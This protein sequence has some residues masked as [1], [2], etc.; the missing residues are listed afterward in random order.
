MAQRDVNVNEGE[1]QKRE[2]KV[3]TKREPWNR[4]L[5]GKLHPLLATRRGKKREKR[6]KRKRERGE[7]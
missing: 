6:E 3:T 4:G 5:A 2:K 7:R 1:E